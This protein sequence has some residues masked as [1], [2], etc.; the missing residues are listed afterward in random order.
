MAP[1]DKPEVILASIQAT[2]R[3]TQIQKVDPK[4]R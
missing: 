4:P 3:A 1:I 2:I